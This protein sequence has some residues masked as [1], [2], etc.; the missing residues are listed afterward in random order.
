[1]AVL[2]LL[3]DGLVSL[4]LGYLAGIAM[5]S[6]LS[7]LIVAL[8]VFSNTLYLFWEVRSQSR[9]A[10]KLHG[11]TKETGERTVN[12]AGPLGGAYAGTFGDG[13]GGGAG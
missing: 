4:M 5:G 12:E 7:G 8:V 6:T 1:M 9:D 11:R 2:R 13:G 3:G 10:G